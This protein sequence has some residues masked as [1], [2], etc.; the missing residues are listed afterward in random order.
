MKILIVPILLS[1]GINLTAQTN[2]IV[3]I[4]SI[5]STIEAKMA[6]LSYDSGVVQLKPTGKFARYET[7][8]YFL[9]STKQLATVNYFRVYVDK[10]DFVAE[11]NAYS[12]WYRDFIDFWYSNGQ[13]V[14]ISH[15]VLV[16]LVD[17]TSLM[18]QKHQYYFSNGKLIHRIDDYFGNNYSNYVILSPDT[19]YQMGIFYLNDYKKQIR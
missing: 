15:N 9:N 4:D 14:K 16:G 17:S 10:E 18:L 19:L 2:S 3:A 13:L 11:G 8:H 7:S 12:G 6:V 5:I 1:F